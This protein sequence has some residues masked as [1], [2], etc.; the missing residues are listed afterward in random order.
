MINLSSFIR[1]HARRTPDRPAL[2]YR[3]ERDLLRR[4]SMRASGKRPAG[5]P[6]R[7]SAPGDVVAVLMKNSAAFL[8][9]VV[10]HQPSRRGV[11][12]RS[13]FGC[14]RDEV[15]Y[16]V[17]NAGARLLIVD[18]ELAAQCSGLRRSSCSNEAAQ[19]EHHAPR[20]RGRARADARPRTVR[21]D[22][23]DVHL[24]HDRPPQRRDAQL[25][26]FL[27]EVAPT[28]RSRSASAPRRDCSSSARSIT[29]ARS[30][31]PASPCSGVAA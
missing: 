20:G 23:P 6:R 26:Q 31:C 16:I 12:C 15:G 22:A 8:E 27:L 30:T 28:S 13:T 29:S 3:G 10:R 17:G 25:R 5:S 1:F 9:L 11:A 18:E 24:G 2:N 7:A 4:V 14:P 21:P 19:Q